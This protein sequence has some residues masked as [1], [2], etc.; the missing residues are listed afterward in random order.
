VT[1]KTDARDLLLDLI[2]PADAAN[3]GTTP[4]DAVADAI[5]EA[6]LN[7][8]ALRHCLVPGCLHEFDMASHM[9][10]DPPPRPSWSGKGWSQL[11]NG[12][13]FPAGG[14][15]CPDHKQLVTDHL[16]RRLQLPNDRWGVDCAC[17][18]TPAPQR[19]HGVLRALWEEHLLTETGKLPPAPP[20]T[21]PEHR[22]PLAEHTEATLTELY[23]RLWDAEH[24]RTETREAAQAMFKAW[25]WHRTVHS[26]V[27]RALNAVRNYMRVAVGDTRDWTADRH[28]AYLWSV[29]IGWDD[30]T[31]Q[32]VAVKHR[33]DEHRIAYVR[34]MRGYLAPI[35]DP[36][37]G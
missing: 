8:P 7:Q 18:W 15:I 16:P 21:D 19:W 24:D 11:G 4:E 25:D 3:R 35:A 5:N 2:G 26:G 28:D 9:N 33:W 17:G 30:D 6:I 27:A 31:L 14:H 10:G 36:Q 1:R 32:E 29:L 37:E 34:E 22:I 20:Q 12:T 13:I 23:D